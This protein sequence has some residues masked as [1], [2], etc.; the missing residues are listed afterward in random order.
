MRQQ[1]GADGGTAGTHSVVFCV[2]LSL[3]TLLFM[4]SPIYI[5]QKAGRNRAERDLTGPTGVGRG[6]RGRAGGLRRRL[7]GG[8]KRG[9]AG[10]ISNVTTV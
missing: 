8:G 6:E 7:G 9:Q 3:S 2:L 10:D 5:L 1:R 4:F